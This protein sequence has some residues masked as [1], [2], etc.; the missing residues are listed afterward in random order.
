[1]HT[2]GTG[3]DLELELVYKN[4]AWELDPSN[5]ATVYVT[6]PPIIITPADMITYK[7][8]EEESG[9]SDVNVVDGEGKPM[10]NDG[11]LPEMGFYLQLSDELN[12]QLSGSN[13]AET[14]DLSKYI[15]LS[16][17]DQDGNE[18]SWKLEKYG[19]GTSVASD[20]NGYFIYKIVPA[21]SD[22]G[23]KLNVTFQDST[24]KYVGTD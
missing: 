14:Q 21:E 16:A 23:T 22:S 1:G 6:C 13:D 17:K 7:G 24:G 19:D 8:G 12:Q 9:S 3:S 4:G 5:P 2:L 11:S 15:T 18:L 10:H 20:D